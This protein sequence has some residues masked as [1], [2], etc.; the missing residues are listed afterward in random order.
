MRDK[1]RRLYRLFYDKEMPHKCTVRLV[2]GVFVWR[3]V[4]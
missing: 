2:S 4:Y 3:D 1:V